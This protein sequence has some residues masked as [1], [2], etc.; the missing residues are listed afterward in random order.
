MTQEM[1]IYSWTHEAWEAMYQD[2]VAAKI[3]IEFE[4]Y[5]VRN[6]EIGQRFLR[7]FAQKARNGLRIRLLLDRVGS[8]KVFHSELI[9]KIREGGGQVIFYNPIGWLNLFTPWAWFPRNH[10]KAVLVDSQ[11]AYVGGVCL[12][13]YMKEWRDMHARLIGAPA[14]AVEEDFSFL[15]KRATT[16]KKQ[17]RHFV[18]QDGKFNYVIAQP[19]LPSNPIYQELLKQINAA[20]DY[21]YIGTPYFLPPGAALIYA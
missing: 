5:I 15:W 6:D 12:A 4:Q 3:S 13:D 21:I 2:C 18:K 19:S 1:K 7:L 17:V 10:V 20:K 8:R 14:H 11:I 9:K 16:R